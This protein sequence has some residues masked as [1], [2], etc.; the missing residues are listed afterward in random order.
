M[1]S[2]SAF[3]A[4]SE[5]DQGASQGDIAQGG[6]DVIILPGGVVL[7]DQASPLAALPC[8]GRPVSGIILCTEEV[9]P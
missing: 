1:A 3:G 5:A 4:P 2:V 6:A 9:E 8:W 7:V